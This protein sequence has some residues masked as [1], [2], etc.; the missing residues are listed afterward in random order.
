MIINVLALDVMAQDFVPYFLRAW[1][2]GEIIDEFDLQNMTKV[3]EKFLMTRRRTFDEVLDAYSRLNQN[4]LNNRY[5][6]EPSEINKTEFTL[7]ILGIAQEKGD[8]NWDWLN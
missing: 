6:L 5:K 4:K 2:K 8:F 3:F 1:R 7:M